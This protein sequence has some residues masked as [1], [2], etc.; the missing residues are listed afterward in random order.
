MLETY[1]LLLFR[2][3]SR[4]SM[5]VKYFIFYYFFSILFYKQPAQNWFRLLALLGRQSKAGCSLYFDLLFLLVYSVRQ[6]LFSYDWA[7]FL[8]LFFVLC[9]VWFPVVVIGRRTC[10]N[11]S[12][13]NHVNN[14][15]WENKTLR[16]F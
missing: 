1:R 4:E 2:H 12:H 3:P 13:T 5:T 11:E 16:Y 14:Q 8:F 6:G 15:S 9:I 7:V 10:D